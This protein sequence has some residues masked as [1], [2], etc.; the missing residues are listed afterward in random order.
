MPVAMQ[1]VGYIIKK[2][3]HDFENT[4]IIGTIL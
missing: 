4:N 1:E 2:A 3:Q